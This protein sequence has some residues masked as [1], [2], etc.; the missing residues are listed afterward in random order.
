MKEQTFVEEDFDVYENAK[1]M[2]D[3]RE[4]EAEIERLEQ[5]LQEI[6]YYLMSIILTIIAVSAL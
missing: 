2:S 4:A 5:Q 1:K 6:V 3:S